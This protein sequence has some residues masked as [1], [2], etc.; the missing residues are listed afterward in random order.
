MTPTARSTRWRRPGLAAC[1][2]QRSCSFRHDTSTNRPPAATVCRSLSRAARWRP[3]RP[4]S[5]Q[6][7]GDVARGAGGVGSS[8]LTSA[9]GQDADGDRRIVVDAAGVVVLGACAGWSLITA[10]MHDGRPEGVLLAVL[11]VAAGYAA[12]RIAGR[13]CRSARPAP[14]PWRVSG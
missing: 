3:V 6:V 12:G 11:A 13:C 14:G 7:G 9:S 8:G 5:S 2:L 4:G 10:A 1:L